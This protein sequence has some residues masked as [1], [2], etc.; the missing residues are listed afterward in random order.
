MTLSVLRKQGRRCAFHVYYYPGMGDAFFCCALHSLAGCGK[1]M[2][3]KSQ[4]NSGYACGPTVNPRMMGRPYHGENMTVT[5]PM[6][7]INGTLPVLL[8]PSTTVVVLATPHWLSLCIKQKRSYV[9][10]AESSQL[11]A[12]STRSTLLLPRKTNSRFNRP[13]L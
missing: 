4:D 3:D 5:T 6:E 12:P 8:I 10:R 11:S 2:E 9:S 1:A 13:S 7:D